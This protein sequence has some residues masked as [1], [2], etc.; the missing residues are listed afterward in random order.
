[1]NALG[2]YGG[3]FDPIHHGH[4]TLARTLRDCFALPQVRLIPTGLPPHR[5]VSR[6]SP[7]QRLAWVQQAV[8][9][10][11]GLAADDREVRRNGYCYTVETL[12]EI[13]REQPDALLVWLIGGDSLMQLDRWRDWHTLLEL[14][15]LVVAARPG[16]DLAALPVEIAEEFAKRHVS[17]T[18]QALARGKISLLPSPLL[19]VSSTELR[20]K[21]VRGEDVSALTPV[22]DAVTQSGLYRF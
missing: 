7:A 10:D 11:P 6:V 3:S 2:I 8:A 17:A 1:M 20:E 12:Q 5:A 18:P 14:G 13:Q 15:H 22:A 19:T 9:G 21:L 4:L 16:Y